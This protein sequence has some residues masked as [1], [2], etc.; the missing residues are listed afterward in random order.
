MFNFVCL[1][2]LQ[3]FIMHLIGEE[4]GGK[5][6]H[7]GKKALYKFIVPDTLV[8][9]ETSRIDQGCYTT[10]YQSMAEGYAEDVLHQLTGPLTVCKRGGLDN[11]GNPIIL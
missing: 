1:L 11:K 8:R 7:P 2:Y 5:I 3:T 6:V 9:P 10:T 4:L